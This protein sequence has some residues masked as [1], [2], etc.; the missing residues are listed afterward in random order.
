[1]TSSEL[2]ES[3]LAYFEGQGHRRRAQLAAGAA[4][5]PDAAVHQR[6]D[7]PV[8][9]R[10]PRPGDSATTRGRRPRRSACASAASTTTSTTSARRSATTRSSRC[11]GNFSFGDYFKQDA[12]AFA[13]ELLTE[14]G[15]CPPTGC[16]R[17]SSRA[18][19]ASRATTRP[20]RVWRTFVPA[21]R[22]LELGASDNFWQM[23]ETGPV[24][25]L[26]GDPLL[27]RQRSALPAP[28][29]LGPACDCDRFVEVWNNVF[30]EFDRQADGVAQAAA[31]AVDRHRHG[32]RAHRRRDP[33][34]DAVELRH[35]PV[36]AVLHAI[37]RARRV[38]ADD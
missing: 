31:E 10:V 35:R 37:E 28:A 20:T 9:G 11:S 3:F 1:M 14:D 18:S 4:R 29:C 5:R 7:E 22:I 24:R 26:L 32:P 25:P 13:W 21:D 19:P 23:G 16:S 36:R 12:I 17:R 15:S 30:M 8:Q 33:E 6:R 34:G 2:R 27:P 38:H